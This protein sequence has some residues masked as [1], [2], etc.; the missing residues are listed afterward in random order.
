[1]TEDDWLRFFPFSKPRAEQIITINAII[2]S[3]LNGKKFFI[4]ELGTGIGKSAI[5]ITVA[6]YMESIKGSTSYILTTQKVLQ[7]QY[8]ADFGQSKL[9]LINSIK[10]SSN[11]NCT[12]SPGYSCAETRRVHDLK[13]K[14]TGEYVSCKDCPYK[15]DK[16][17][18]IDSPLGITNFAYFF[19]ETTY[20]RK[21]EP[22]DLLI[23][24]EAHNIE[25]ALS[26]FI[27]VTFS[28]KF[29]KDALKCRPPADDAQ[30]SV[31]EWIGKKYKKTLLKRLSDLEKTLSENPIDETSSKDA[32]QYEL[33]DKHVC[34]VNR[35]LDAYDVENWVMNVVNDH[36][37]KTKKYEFK[38]VNVGCFADDTLYKF[39]TQVLLMS[40]TILDVGTFCRSIGIDEKSVDSIRLGSPF[41]IESRLV[42]YMPVGHMSK[43]K[44]DVTL[45]SM[46]LVIKAIMEQ[47][48]GE[49]GIIHT[50][51]FRIAQYI[52]EALSS[53]RLLIHNSE[54]REA[55]LNRHMADPNP[56]ILISPSMTEGV[57][58]LNDASRFQ[59]LCKVPFPYLG[60]EVIRRRMKRDNDWYP[61]QTAKSVIQ[62]LGRS[63]RNEHDY[64]VSYILD[65]DWEY[66]YR[67]NKGFF[68]T[69]FDK[70][71]A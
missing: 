65:A 40:A 22:R 19:A 43:D 58:L 6:R 63:I 33:L 37:K 62:S 42:H 25:Q 44:I 54:N 38:P 14:I 16:K 47:H 56:T 51:N 41:P 28:T 10:S 11:Y 7:D 3:F 26:A 53:K 66:F 52:F 68:P 30:A 8:V 69:D 50:T 27:E 15:L 4:A 39:G 20:A 18:F 31:V 59:V 61:Y 70:T 9:K 24:D 35:F 29:A 34:K 21:L 1:M 13:R 60:D 45:P 2:N 32:K 23:I 36:K 12:S 46:A 71:L 67:K 5:A 48:V 17:A 64:A 55:V 57:N 49:K